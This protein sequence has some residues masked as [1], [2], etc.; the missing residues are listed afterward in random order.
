MLTWKYTTPAFVIPIAFALGP[1]GAALLLD[2]TAA[3]IAIMTAAAALGV[4]GI[5]AGAGGWIR[6][7]A[8][9]AERV[10]A[11]AGGLLVLAPA[12]AVA[13]SGT[14]LLATTV[15]LHLVRI[16]RRPVQSPG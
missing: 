15:V 9:P 13:A 10:L 3:D 14:I 16:G 12:T 2:G 6:G 5:A 4:A 8:T 7:R 11:V 1:R